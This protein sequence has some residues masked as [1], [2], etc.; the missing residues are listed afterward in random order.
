MEVSSKTGENVDS[1]FEALARKILLQ[2]PTSIEPKIC[3]V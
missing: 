3:V 1:L 2:R